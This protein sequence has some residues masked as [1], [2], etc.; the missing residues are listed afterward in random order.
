MW[1]ETHGCVIVEDPSEREA[2]GPGWYE[3]PTELARA[4]A[5]AQE[6]VAKKGRKHDSP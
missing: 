3:T 1:H 4:L 2:L 5:Q 6:P